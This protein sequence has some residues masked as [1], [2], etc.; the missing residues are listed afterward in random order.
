M[1]FALATEP[2]SKRW[3][4]S[5]KVVVFLL[6]TLFL[7]TQVR[8]KGPANAH[9]RPR[10]GE[11][12]AAAGWVGPPPPLPAGS[13]PAGGSVCSSNQV[14]RASP[15]AAASNYTPTLPARQLEKGIVAYGDRARARRAFSKLLRG[16]PIT[17]V[18]LGGSVTS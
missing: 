11:A 9:L 4:T 3:P 12:W 8:V 2:A 14:W 18:L 1:A 15:H 10:W 7:L 16:E 6:G 13:G 17:V 5:A